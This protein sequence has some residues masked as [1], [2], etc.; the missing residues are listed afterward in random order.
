ME[1][2]YITHEKCS[3]RREGEHLKLVRSG[4]T[5]AT[6]PII[7]VKTIVVLD[8]VS[9]TSCALN[10]LLNNG[11]DVIYQSQWGKIKG[12]VLSAKGGGAI[13]RLA[14]FSA[15]TNSERRLEI[16]KSVVSAKIHNQL[17]VV[18]KY[19][20]HDSNPAF[21]GHI[22]AIEVNARKLDRASMLDEVMG[23]EGISAKYYWD[24][25][26]HLL[27]DSVFTRREYRPSPDYVNAL[28]NLGYAFLCNEITACL[29]VKKLD[30]EV[31]FLHSIHYGRNSLALD[32]MEE[33][34]PVFI[35]SWI[36]AVLNKKQLKEDHFQMRNGDWRLTEDGFKK[37]CG[38][39]YERIPAWRERFRA[40]ADIL[41]NALI[42]GESYESYRE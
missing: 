28:L 6:I 21:D 36:I 32:I 35:D 8:N 11:V 9:V 31:G 12:R 2:L 27:K 15:F 4:D 18:K 41:K 10:M 25:F 39:Y 42:K 40:Q 30:P 26:R 24:C 17:S 23:I 37:F 38:L 34:R 13:V 14:Q 3:V 20:Y 7:G 1:T 33:F 29:I 5:L 19:K 16:A 22:S